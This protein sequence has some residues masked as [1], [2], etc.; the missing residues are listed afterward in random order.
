MTKNFL[1]EIFTSAIF[2]IFLTSSCSMTLPVKGTVQNSDE[3]FQGSATG[4][5]G[6][7]EVLR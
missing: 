4:Y 5:L 1:Y 6:G 7:A 2:L 3:T